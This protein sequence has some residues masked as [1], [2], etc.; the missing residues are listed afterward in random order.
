MSNHG[1]ITSCTLELSE[2]SL[3]FGFYKF[4]MHSLPIKRVVHRESSVTKRASLELE[5]HQTLN[6][7]MR[8]YLLLTFSL[9]L[10][11]TSLLAAPQS[12]KISVKAPSPYE[13]IRCQCDNYTW[14]DTYGKIQVAA[15]NFSK[16]QIT[17]V[18]IYQLDVSFITCYHNLYRVTARALMQLEVGGAMSVATIAMTSNTRRTAGISTV[19]C[20]DGHT[21]PVPHLHLAMVAAM[22]V[23]V[24]KGMAAATVATTTTGL[25][26]P[27][28]PT[29]EVSLEDSSAARV[30]VLLLVSMNVLELS[31]L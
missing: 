19:S 10:L 26:G 6:A 5:A 28:D 25:K 20:G 23:G 31:L 9:L 15:V 11:A 29:L 12:K 27:T 3:I 22:V 14:R 16:S 17:C 4:S 13:N 18:Q 2:R 8:Q 21:R 24:M 1:Y 30:L 7:I